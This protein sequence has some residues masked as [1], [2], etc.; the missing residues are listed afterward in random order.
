MVFFL[1]LHLQSTLISIF[2]FMVLLEGTIRIDIVYDGQL[3]V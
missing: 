1:F 3:R 2:A